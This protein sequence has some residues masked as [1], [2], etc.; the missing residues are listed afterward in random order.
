M[1]KSFFILISLVSLLSCQNPNNNKHNSLY[2]NY[3]ASENLNQVD[4]IQTFKFQGWN[5]LDYRHLIISS[6]HN[7]SYL[8]TLDFYCNDLLSTTSI[9]INQTI[10][11]NLSAKF[12]SISVPRN[13]D[14]ECRIKSIHQLSKKQKSE[15]TA[16]R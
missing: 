7:K 16:L 13:Q 8:I 14:F 9:I 5:S 11:S 1:N 3:V 12:D 15:I 6:S 4:K 10:S 2:A